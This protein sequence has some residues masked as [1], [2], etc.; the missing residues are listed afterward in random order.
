MGAAVYSR[1]IAAAGT[2][3]DR[4]CATDS[5]LALICPLKA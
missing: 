4:L 1:W 2:P 3:T 5:P